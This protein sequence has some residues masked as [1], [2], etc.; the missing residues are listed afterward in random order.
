MPDPPS[1]SSSSSQGGAAGP[2]GDRSSIDGSS[3]TTSESGDS[4]PPRR[5][6]VDGR[7]VPIY[8]SSD[9]FGDTTIKSGIVEGEDTIEYYSSFHDGH[10]MD[11]TIVQQFGFNQDELMESDQE[12]IPYTPEHYAMNESSSMM[13]KVL[14]FCLVI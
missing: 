8:S 4:S 1:S 13:K 11:D 2:G 7:E 5:R 14:G 3:V 12:T 9:G 6:A 10:L